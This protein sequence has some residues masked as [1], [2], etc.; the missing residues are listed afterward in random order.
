MKAVLFSG[1]G[2][3]AKGMGIQLLKS[4]PRNSKYVETWSRAREALL[5]TFGFDITYVIQDNP[6]HINARTDPTG[7]LEKITT[8]HAGGL[9]D[10]TPFTQ[11]ALVTYQM[12]LWEEGVSRGICTPPSTN[13]T[14]TMFAGH[15]LGEFSALTAMGVLSVE[16]AVRL[17]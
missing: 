14:K 3:Q 15:S 9:L 10:H 16:D 13:N 1:Q 12:A 6:N 8:H 7:P 11:A 17:V 4:L 2:S 5:D